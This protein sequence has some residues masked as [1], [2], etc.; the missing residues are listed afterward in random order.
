[1]TKRYDMKDSH[2][3][4]WMTE[5]ADGDWV[6]YD[7]HLA[8]L[9]AAEARGFDAGRASS[10]AEIARLRELLTDALVWLRTDPESAKVPAL[11]RRIAAHLDA[12]ETP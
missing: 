8:A 3:G 4:A 12:K 1:M 10:R 7:D 2:S 6:D 5:D 9:D 11:V